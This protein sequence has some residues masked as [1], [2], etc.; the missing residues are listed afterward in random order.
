LLFF[1]ALVAAA[2]GVVVAVVPRTS[3]GEPSLVE[4]LLP[5]TYFNGYIT[6][7]DQ[8]G[9]ALPEDLSVDR[10]TN[11]ANDCAGGGM[12][13]N[14]PEY[15]DAD[16][17]GRAR[18]GWVCLMGPQAGVPDS[19]CLAPG[20][21][22]WRSAQGPRLPELRFVVHGHLIGKSLGGEG[23]A[24][25][26]GLCVNMVPQSREPNSRMGV[27][28]ERRAKGLAESSPGVPFLYW[29]VPVYTG[30]S[31]MPDGIWVFIVSRLGAES[32]GP[33]VNEHV[34]DVGGAP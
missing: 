23:S 7:H 1:L 15:V 14:K 25:R 29:V 16:Q 33:F 19:R 22:D 28:A 9:V 34:G 20:S 11:R 2:V 21:N 10:M 13:P 5:Q 24:T 8:Y 26:N 12:P 27:Q 32:P 4:S 17:Y 31:Y 3:G 30:K 18:G 6:F